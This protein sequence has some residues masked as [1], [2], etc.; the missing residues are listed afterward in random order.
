MEKNITTPIRT[1]TPAPIKTRTPTPIRTPTPAPI[2]PPNEISD[3]YSPTCNNMF[4]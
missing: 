2:K 4:S 3:K 1:P